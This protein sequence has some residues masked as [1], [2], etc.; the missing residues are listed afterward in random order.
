[1]R[2][3]FPVRILAGGSCEMRESPA[4]CARVGNYVLVLFDADRLETTTT[5]YNVTDIILNV[6]L[7][8]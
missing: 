8:M 5:I 3:L 2:E 6:N 7:T 1:M 4:E